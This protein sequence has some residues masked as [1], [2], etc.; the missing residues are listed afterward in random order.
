MVVGQLLEKLAFR[1]VGAVGGQ[2]GRSNDC[3]GRV[4]KKLGRIGEREVEVA[5]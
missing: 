5:A 1:D 2:D 3:Y 4:P